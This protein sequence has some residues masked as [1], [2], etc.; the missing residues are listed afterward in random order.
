MAESNQ[1]ITDRIKGITGH[2]S[3]ID[4]SGAATHLPTAED[5]PI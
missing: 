4:I 3:Y 2:L 5:Y 1:L